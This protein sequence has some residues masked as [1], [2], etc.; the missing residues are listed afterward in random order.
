L[1]KDG[2]MNILKAVIYAVN[3][4]AGTLAFGHAGPETKTAMAGTFYKTVLRI[5]HGCD[6]TPTDTVWIKIP[7]DRITVKPEPKPG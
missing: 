4:L 7:K 1:I 2:E 5:P 6:G 3:T